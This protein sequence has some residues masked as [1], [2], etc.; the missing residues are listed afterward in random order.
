MILFLI[1]KKQLIYK[2]SMHKLYHFIEI[3]YEIK[4]S[5]SDLQTETYQIIDLKCSDR[6]YKEDTDNTKDGRF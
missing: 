6:S 5:L 1:Y 3:S 4:K 2:I